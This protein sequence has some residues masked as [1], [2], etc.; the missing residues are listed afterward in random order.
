MLMRYHVIM[1]YPD[2]NPP[3]VLSRGHVAEALIVQ[4]W[5][6]YDQGVTARVVDG[7]DT[8]ETE[9]AVITAAWARM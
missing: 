6:E 3:V 4:Q 5:S 1:E 9:V 2:A 7:L 8:T